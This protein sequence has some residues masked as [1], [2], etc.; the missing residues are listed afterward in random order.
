M[1]IGSVVSRTCKTCGD[2]FA[3]TVKGR[4]RWPDYCKRH[5]PERQ[6]A[7]VDKYRQTEK[8]RKARDRAVQRQKEKYDP[9]LWENTILEWDE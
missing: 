2:E 3:H 7:A 9:W 8:Y 4:G 1:A 6:R 5:R